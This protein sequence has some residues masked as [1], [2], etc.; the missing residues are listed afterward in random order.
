MSCLRLSLFVPLLVSVIKSGTNL[1]NNWTKHE[2]IDGLFTMFPGNDEK[3]DNWY[4]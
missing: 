2:P 3:I 1:S 4:D